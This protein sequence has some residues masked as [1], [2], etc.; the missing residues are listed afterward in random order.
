VSGIEL[1]LAI[2]D[3]SP[4]P[5]PSPEAEP[6]NPQPLPDSATRLTD[7]FWDQLGQQREMLQQFQEGLI[8]PV[9]HLQQAQDFL[10][11][12]GTASQW[13][14][15]PAPRTPFSV[16]LSPERRVAFSE[17]S[18]VEIREIRTALG[19]TVNDV[20]LAILAGA[21]R[22]YLPARG[23]SVD[24]P[25][26]RVAI[27][28]NV[29]VEDEQS[30]MGNRVSC[31][32]TELPIKEAD[33]A[34]RLNTIRERIDLLK[35]TDQA[36]S[37]ELLARMATLAPVPVQAAGGLVP[38][39][40]TVVNLIC[41]NVPGP[42]IPLYSIGH[43]MLAHYPL[44]PLSLDLGLAVGVTSYNQRLYFGLMADPKAVPDVE[45][46]K[47]CLDESFL[48]LR[49]AA[50]VGPSDLPA[51]GGQPSSNGSRAGAGAGGV[52]KRF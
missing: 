25:E 48:E 43:L 22:R 3:I 18:F 49:T 23:H 42:M 35:Q 28:V 7:A 15:R 5:A 31:M 45:R 51:F 50:G 6:W 29:R 41:T 4:E 1:L 16:W 24:G 47:E 21:L 10:G 2:F 14:A 52:E 30:A 34:A 9:R 13:F 12:L 39:E 8:D 40:N 32:L 46:L 17:M 33:P 27:P 26:L 19:G 36:G 20:V 44:V 37:I 38:T 11:A